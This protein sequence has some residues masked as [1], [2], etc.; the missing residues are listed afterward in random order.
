M[1]SN[2]VDLTSIINAIG[3]LTGGAKTQEQP[4]EM[5]P[6]VKDVV[7]STAGTSKVDINQILQMVALFAPIVQALLSKL[8][9]AP[10]PAP[11]PAPPVQTAPTPA[12]TPTPAPAPV[13]PSTGRRV[14]ASFRPCHWIG[15][16]DFVQRQGEK[17][18]YHHL[19]GN[20]QGIVSGSDLVGR[21]Y[22]GHVDMTP[23]DQ[24]G[25]PFYNDDLPKYPELF[26]K[27]PSLI[28]QDANGR[29]TCG[30]GNNRIRHYINVNGQRFG[31]M[32]DTVPGRA[33]EGQ[34]ICGLTSETDDAAMTPVVLINYD[35]PLSTDFFVFY[36]AEYEAPDGSIIPVGK[37]STVHVKAWEVVGQA[38]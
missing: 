3:L 38:A 14:I 34:G 20:S 13:T 18:A 25:Q 8:K 6:V 15:W 5:S 4:P 9:K 1:S 27:T 22:R 7:R 19:I 37:T 12:T 24:F 26:A 23:L 30:E 11:A 2:A 21:G 31:P 16:E 28:S 33:W 36:E 29:W 35:I 17:Q 32:G 10:A